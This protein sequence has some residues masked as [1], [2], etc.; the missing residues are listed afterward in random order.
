MKPFFTPGG[1]DE[2]KC[3]YLN[4]SACLKRVRTSRTESFRNLSPSEV[5]VSRNVV[6]VSD[7]SAVNFIVEWWL[8][9]CSIPGCNI[10]PLFMVQSENMS[11]MFLSYS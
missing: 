5:V 4:V 11:S 10:T 8:L 3:V 7:I 2:M 1:W 9:A 6:S